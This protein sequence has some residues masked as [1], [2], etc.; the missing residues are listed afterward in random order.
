MSFQN[1]TLSC[2][3]CGAAFDFTVEE[4]VFQQEVGLIKARRR[5]LEEERNRLQTQLNDIERL[6]F[7]PEAIESLRQRFEERLTR[8]TPEDQRFVLESLGAKVVA[9]PNGTW[10]MEIELPRQV[11]SNMQIEHSVPESDSP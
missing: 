10:D 4:Q 7:S 11:P 6:S 8:A 9:Y 1:K 3:D 2:A 5:W